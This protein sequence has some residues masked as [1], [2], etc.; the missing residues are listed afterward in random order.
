MPC[1]GCQKRRQKIGAF[2]SH[3]SPWSPEPEGDN[4][5]ELRPDTKELRIGAGV[6]YRKRMELIDRYGGTYTIVD[7]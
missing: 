3:I 6:P 5:F 7:K 1:S 4:S 2:L